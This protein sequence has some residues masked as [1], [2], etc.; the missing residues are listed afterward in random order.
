MVQYHYRIYRDDKLPGA[1][2]HQSCSRPNQRISLFQNQAK[3]YRQRQ[4]VKG[5]DDTGMFQ[6]ENS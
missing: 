3:G 1:A 2:L 6:A 4:T 5:M